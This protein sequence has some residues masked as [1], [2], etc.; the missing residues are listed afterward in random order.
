MG[1]R[2]Y[3]I[4]KKYVRAQGGRLK[5]NLLAAPLLHASFH[6]LGKYIGRSCGLV[7]CQGNLSVARESEHA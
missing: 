5:G 6:L 2:L 1:S 3:S 4:G 7:V